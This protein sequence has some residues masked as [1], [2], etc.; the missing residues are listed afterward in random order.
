MVEK[1]YKT[2]EEWKK[3]LTPAQYRVMREKKTENPFTCEFK[4]YKG[5]KGIYYCAA[6][7]LPLFKTEKKFESGTGW[8]SFYE[9]FGKGR[10]SFKKD[11][12]RIEVLCAR[13]DSHLGHV[14]GDGPPPSNKRYCINGIALK[15]KGDIDKNG[16]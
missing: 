10:L 11:D 12:N 6:C 8:P 14:F 1:I 16:K 2:E 3:I 9:P 4:E 13:C 5:E 15:F 7:D